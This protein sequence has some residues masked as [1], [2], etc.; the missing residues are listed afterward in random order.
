MKYSDEILSLSLQ[1]VIDKMGD[2]NVNLN[3]FEFFKE[4]LK[5]EYPHLSVGDII[6]IYN[7]QELLR[8]IHGWTA[9]ERLMQ[10]MEIEHIQ[11]MPFKVGE[12]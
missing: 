12:L 5:K 1:E 6:H 7:N 8:T 9:Y 4:Y 2:R 11:N 3:R 10:L